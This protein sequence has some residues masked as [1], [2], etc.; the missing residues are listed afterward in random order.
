V[1][2][3][4]TRPAAARGLS[5]VAAGIGIAFVDSARV[6]ALLV[7][8]LLAGIA[9]MLVRLDPK[10]VLGALFAFVLLV[11]DDPLSFG[12]GFAGLYAR[13]NPVPVSVVDLMTLAV[14][15]C[16]LIARLRRSAGHG[17]LLPRQL[18]ALCV[19]TLAAIAIGLPVGIALGA[20]GADALNGARVLLY[21][22]FL[23][24]AMVGALETRKDV[25]TAGATFIALALV[26]CSM[27]V[28]AGVSGLGRPLDGVHINF[29]EPAANWAGV[30]V[31]LWAIGRMTRRSFG[32]SSVAACLAGASL[33]ASYR[34]SFWVA[35]V[36][37][38]VVVVGYGMRRSSRLFLAGAAVAFVALLSNG[39]LPEP[40]PESAN[41][42]VRR[43]A[44][45][46]PAA[47]ADDLGGRY[48]S[49]ERANTLETL[50]SSWAIGRGLGGHWVEHVPM[51]HHFP[52]ENNYV[53]M[54]VLWYALKLGVV[55]VG[56]YILLN[57]A[58]FTLCR[59]AT[60]RA[61][62]V[63]VDP[64]LSVALLGA[65]AGM[66][67]AEL[68]ASFTGVDLRLTVLVG[69]ALGWVAA[70]L[71]VGTTTEEAASSARA[72]ST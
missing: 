54:A 68:T 5:F 45:A 8:G 27:G 50:E 29:Y 24:V 43:V 71:S 22:A 49:A 66:L 2:T 65:S 14:A 38:A 25:Q 30:V 60:R 34:R 19:A 32:L 36:V 20:S 18:V 72:T 51:P 1:L 53:H 46:R 67:L 64:A 35:A 63:G 13:L 62:D 4:W 39:L 15:G 56:L 48:R 42:V 47:F 7:G 69:L 44:A 58:L 31:L 40:T 59:A 33:I 21:L 41:P 12:G 23:P 61:V 55:G 26:K 70:A 9:L 52:G 17:P 11:E 10:P 16:L 37:G 3:S 6:A 57:V 28:V